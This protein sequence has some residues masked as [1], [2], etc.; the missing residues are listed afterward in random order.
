MRQSF[1]KSIQIED[2]EA[3]Q[4]E[5]Q[6]VVQ[7]TNGF[8]N[9]YHKDIKMLLKQIQSPSTPIKPC[10]DLVHHQVVT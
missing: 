3:K 2:G 7:T 9:Q 8:N 10:K 1:W 6:S 4:A 5:H